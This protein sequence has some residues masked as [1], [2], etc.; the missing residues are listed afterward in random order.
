MHKISVPLPN[1]AASAF[2]L[3]NLELSASLEGL[4]EVHRA[5]QGTLVGYSRTPQ[6]L[7]WSEHILAVMMYRDCIIREIYRRGGTT[8]HPVMLVR[9]PYEI[10]WEP[11][12]YTIP[13]W[14]GNFDIHSAER[15]RLM[16]L[17][18]DSWYDQWGWGDR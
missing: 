5:I 12:G 3:H 17:S 10:P 18:R 16:S 8:K 15:K 2:S 14:L 9:T 6:F 4:V 1:F 11:Q 13:T 7:M